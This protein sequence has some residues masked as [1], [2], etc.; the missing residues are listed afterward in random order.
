MAQI[1]VDLA[2]GSPCIDGRETSLLISIV[3]DYDTPPLIASLQEIMT[4]DLGAP[5]AH[6]TRWP[7]EWARRIIS[8][9]FQDNTSASNGAA[10]CVA[11]QL[12][13]TIV[14]GTGPDKVRPARR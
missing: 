10:T 4:M 3:R 6:P 1:Y 7:R 2:F 9:A 13:Q 11:V 8:K 12:S 14:L 5:D